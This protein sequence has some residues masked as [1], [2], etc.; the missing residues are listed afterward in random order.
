VTG[1]NICC[2]FFGGGVLTFAC[3]FVVRRAGGAP[4]NSILVGEL[5]QVFSI[6]DGHPRVDA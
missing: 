2:V 1:R 6:S 4:T 3:A 5:I